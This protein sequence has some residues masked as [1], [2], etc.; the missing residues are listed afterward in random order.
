[1]VRRLALLCFAVVLVLAACGG[2][3]DPASTPAGRA[4]VVLL[5]DLYNGRFEKA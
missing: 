2:D 1:V 3:I 4:Q 5:D